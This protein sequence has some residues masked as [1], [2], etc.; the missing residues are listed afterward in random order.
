MSVLFDAAASS[1]TAGASVTS[2]SWSHTVGTAADR[3]LLVF[4]DRLANTVVINSVA[5]G[6]QL[7]SKIATVA[8]TGG[9]NRRC[10]LYALTAPTSGL[11]SVTVTTDTA[12]ALI[13]G[14]LSF[15]GVDQTNPL[16]SPIASAAGTAV[17]SVSVA[18]TDAVAGE[19]LI[20]GSISLR[21]TTAPT[22][23]VN[24]TSRWSILE[25][26]NLYGAGATLDPTA[27]QTFSYSWATADQY[28]L[29]AV[30][31]KQV[32]PTPPPPTGPTIMVRSADNSTWERRK[33][34]IRN[35]ANDTW[36]WPV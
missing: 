16:G 6:G 22:P 9:I 21:E 10:D 12:T 8:S 36:V 27:S 4:V 35:A 20:A 34:L 29:I 11:A 2:L 13:V 32:A 28:A 7:L 26:T 30:A 1:N 24:M 14:S 31:V 33:L 18:V 5:Y 19:D 15:S 25:G 23:N 3:V 17:A